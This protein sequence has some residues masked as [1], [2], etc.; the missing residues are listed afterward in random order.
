LGL[1]IGGT[2]DRMSIANVT[3]AIEANRSYQRV[4]RAQVRNCSC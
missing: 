3:K 1:A 4:L 2:G